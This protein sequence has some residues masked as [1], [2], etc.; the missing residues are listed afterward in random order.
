MSRV[1]RHVPARLLGGLLGAAVLTLSGCGSGG[2]SAGEP[3]SPPPAD[4]HTM[5]DG[6][7]MEGE[8]HESPGGGGSHGGDHHASAGEGPSP[9]AEM[10]CAGDVVDDVNRIM[11]TATPVTPTSGWEEPT[12]TCNFNLEEGPVVLTV[13][14]AVARDAGMAHFRALRA[15][16]TDA[17]TITGV[18]SLGLPAF[19][20][21][22]GIVAF[23]RDGKTL[24]VDTTGLRGR[25]FGVDG[26]QSRTE[27][28]YAM[29]AGVL[30]CWTEHA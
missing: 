11:D 18:Y 2:Q 13:H 29:A 8:T 23:I 7:V 9:A 30:A 26:D 22:D 24:Q 28:A 3:E 20:T 15:G 1:S 27:V 5:P 10:V 25:A 17:A 12:F 6:T 21:P 4:T 16:S 14:D 19:E